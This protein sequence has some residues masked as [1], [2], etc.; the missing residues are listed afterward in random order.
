MSGLESINAINF[1]IE[2]IPI[3]FEK[4]RKNL[5]QDILFLKE[6]ILKEFRQIETTL[7]VKYERQYNSTLTKLR[8]FE[9]TIESMNNKIMELSNLL[10]T[11]KHIK[12][13]LSNLFE[14]KQ[15]VSDTIIS[16][17]INIKSNEST[18]K[19]AIN[20]Y[21]KILSETVLYPGVIGNNCQFQKFHNFIDYVITNIK[22]FI[23][24]NEKY[25]IDFVEYK[26]KFES[27]FKSLQLKVDSINAFN[28]RYIDDKNKEIEEKL[29]AFKNFQDTKISELKS[30]NSN[31][32]SSL[33]NKIDDINKEIKYMRETKINLS[34]KIEKE[35]ELIKNF[36]NGVTNKF[37]IYE[38]EISSVKDRYNNYDE[39]MQNMKTKLKKE[40]NLFANNLIEIRKNQRLMGQNNFSSGHSNFSNYNRYLRRGTIARS[41]VKQYIDG[42]IGINEL[43]NNSPKKRSTILFNDNELKNILSFNKNNKSNNSANNV[44]RIKRMTFGPDKFMNLHKLDKSVVNKFVDNSDQ[45]NNSISEEKSEEIDY[46]NSVNEQ[47]N[48]KENNVSNI[49]EVD[50]NN[51]GINPVDKKNEVINRENIKEGGNINILNNCE[52]GIEVNFTSKINNNMK[53][54]NDNKV[55]IKRQSKQINYIKNE[56]ME[57]QNNNSRGNTR[58]ISYEKI[59]NEKNNSFPK[60]ANKTVDFKK[61]YN[62]KQYSSTV[63][64]LCNIGGNIDIINNYNSTNTNK[65]KLNKTSILFYDNNKIKLNTNNYD[66]INNLQKRTTR[67][68]L[69]IIEV[70]FDEGKAS[71]KEEDELK[72]LI[73][74]I[75]ENRINFL[76]ERNG[77]HLDKKN[78]LYRKLSIGDFDA[79]LIN[80]SIN[81]ASANNNFSNYYLYNRMIKDDFRIGNSLG[82]LNYLKNNKKVLGVHKMNLNKTKNLSGNFFY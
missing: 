9:T 13:K 37:K 32:Y 10:S 26:T 74:R 55:E 20:K 51:S 68:K 16:L 79:G 67:N 6:D 36:N 30:E 19:E 77:R 21:D 50:N 1:S 34:D 46:V 80:N 28:N 66:N 53:N 38:N 45:S 49:L 8:K 44:S 42:E 61:E 27:L 7:N 71:I 14:F 41:I 78:K 5:K 39:F 59:N 29:K 23:N 48:I 35:I 40:N 33:E 69:N 31:F 76:S 24:Y 56:I 47:K 2:N 3:I 70:N 72:T 57:N 25:K 65:N 15:K 60:F 81:G 75:K 22:Q 58:T 64:K 82:Y 12:Q 63:G 18:I 62:Q 54:E 52:K 73:K 11:D 17:Q 4:Q 43:E